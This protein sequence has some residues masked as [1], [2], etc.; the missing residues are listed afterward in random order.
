MSARA[1]APYTLGGPRYWLATAAW[2]I[3]AVALEWFHGSDAARGPPPAVPSTVTIGALNVCGIR[4]LLASQFKREQ[5]R[6]LL[7]DHDHA[8]ELPRCDV[9]CLSE[10]ATKG[11]PP[12]TVT[13]QRITDDICPTGRALWTQHCG[14]ILHNSL[15]GLTAHKAYASPDGRSILALLGKANGTITAAYSAV[16]MHGGDTAQRKTNLNNLADLHNLVPAGVPLTCVGDWN[17]VLQPTIDT[18]GCDLS[19]MPNEGLQQWR[20]MAKAGGLVELLDAFGGPTR[21]RTELTWTKFRTDTAD[22]TL[23]PA[24]RLDFFCINAAARDLIDTGNVR[25]ALTTVPPWFC[26]T[27]V[28]SRAGTDHSSIFLKTTTARAAKKEKR[29]TQANATILR[30]RVPGEPS[31][32][33]R[34]TPI[35]NEAIKAI[36]TATA[37]GDD[38]AAQRLQDR[39]MLDCVCV[40]YAEHEAAVLAHRAET[41]EVRAVLAEIADLDDQ[42]ATSARDRQDIDRDR[43]RCL[44]KFRNAIEAVATGRIGW[45][46]KANHGD[47]GAISALAQQHRS[48]TVFSTMKIANANDTD[49]Q[50]PELM[51]RPGDRTRYASAAGWSCPPSPTVQPVTTEIGGTHVASQAAMATNICN[52]YSV[53]FCERPVNTVAQDECLR[54]FPPDE[55]LPPDVVRQLGAPV[56]ESELRK[57]IPLL[58]D[59]KSPDPQG[60]IAELIK[61]NADQ[62]ATLMTLTMNASFREGKLSVAQRF[63]LLALVYKKGDATDL[64]NYRGLAKCSQL[65]KLTGLMIAERWKRRLPAVI[66][67][68]QHGFMFLRMLFENI[69]KVLD[70]GDSADLAADAERLR[71]QAIASDN[72]GDG[73]GDVGGGDGDDDGDDDDEDTDWQHDWT[74]AIYICDRTKAFDRVSHLW[75]VR[76]YARLCGVD[77]PILEVLEKYWDARRRQLQQHGLSPS[78]IATAETEAKIADAI[79]PAPDVLRL[80]YEHSHTPDA[81]RWIIVLLR[82]HTRKASFNGVQSAAW[83]LCCSIFQGCTWAPQGWSTNADPEA[84][85]QLADPGV[86]GIP[87]KSGGTMLSSRYA[88]DTANGIRAASAAALLDNNVRWCMASAGGTHPHK[89]ALM[90]RGALRNDGRIWENSF[91]TAPAPAHARTK[92]IRAHGVVESLGILDGGSADPGTKSCDWN[93]SLNTHQRPSQAQLDAHREELAWGDIT[94]N[95]IASLR[96][97]SRCFHSFDARVVVLTTFYWS[98]AWYTFAAHPLPEPDGKNQGR[99]MQYLE[100]A[101]YAYL[102]TGGVPPQLNGVADTDFAAVSGSYTALIKRDKV[103]ADARDSGLGFAPPAITGR[104]MLLGTFLEIFVPKTANQHAQTG[105]QWFVFAHDWLMEAIGAAATDPIGALLEHDGW[106]GTLQRAAKARVPR[107]WRLIARSWQLLTP[108]VVINRPTTHE[109]VLSEPIYGGTLGLTRQ[110]GGALDAANAS[111]IGDLWDTTSRT[112]RRSLTR[113]DR[114]RVYDAIPAPWLHILRDGSTAIVTSDWILTSTPIAPLHGVQHAA[115][116]M[117]HATLGVLYLVGAHI[118]GAV[119]NVVEY[120]LGC[121]TKWTRHR[122]LCAVVPATARRATVLPFNGT[123]GDEGPPEIVLVGETATSWADSA[124]RITWADTASGNASEYVVLSSMSDRRSRWTH[125]RSKGGPPQPTSNATAL[126]RQLQPHNTA[127]MSHAMR[128]L[129][130][131]HWT[132]AVRNFAWTCM[133]NCLPNGYACSGGGNNECP[134]CGTVQSVHH[135]ASECAGLR[136]ARRWLREM[137]PILRLWVNRDTVAKF[138]LVGKHRYIARRRTTLVLRGVFFAQ[139]R[140]QRNGTLHGQAQ[141]TRRQVYEAMDKRLRAAILKDW[142]RRQGR[143]EFVRRWRPLVDVRGGTPTVTLPPWDTRKTDARRT[144]KMLSNSAGNSL[145]ITKQLLTI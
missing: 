86:H 47:A 112:W 51:S 109:E 126:H 28:D 30:T 37:N 111:R 138:V 40:A 15:D 134:M 127:S 70:A 98:Q 108:H 48:K 58:K 32:S 52:N 46:S 119:Y 130:R 100:C 31:Y 76:C 133:A 96:R 57:I 29:R 93:P 39:A 94:T 140:A 45:K 87:S 20:A 42:L 59:G 135:E 106:R 121:N 2:L 144:Y 75:L 113:N 6:W 80:Y 38:A 7:D 137:A 18:L 63:G 71:R 143:D 33:E 92:F 72:D 123:H 65:Y 83:K 145:A 1:P 120:L 73:D 43:D 122:G 81:V 27:A 50:G 125:A 129:R 67:E 88:D 132:T 17:L 49:V 34:A 97:H 74:Y 66:L 136:H 124:G 139:W 141:R 105:A 95:M 118:G 131:S 19:T 102:W 117:P 116:G 22:K 10:V 41:S 89:Q 16:Y 13:W 5:L 35:L 128:T 25:D 99:R 36:K 21:H 62:W 78:E 82:E 4:D 64:A 54:T 85:L 115:T 61:E 90:W 91:A 3:M 12:D 110:R 24:K 142:V 55:C 53:L 68:C 14:L 56:C 44:Y 11:H 101:S 60:A 84:R 9:L 114:R 107:R 69:F 79:G 77:L 8:R 103:S 104:A 23:P 26:A